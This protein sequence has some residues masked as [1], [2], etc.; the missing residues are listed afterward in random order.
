HIYA[1]FDGII[2]ARNTDVGALIQNGDNTVPPQ[3]FHL[4]AVHKLRVY[5]SVPEVYA[6]A[7]KSDEIVPLTLDAFPGETFTGTLVRDSGSIDLTS[8]TLKVEVDVDNPTGRLY[9]EL[10]HSFI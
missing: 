7:A 3:L 6:T 8:R 2:T 4:A 5:I 9:P 10:M 1:R